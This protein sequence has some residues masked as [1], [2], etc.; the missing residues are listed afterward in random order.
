[1]TEETKALVESVGFVTEYTAY[2]TRILANRKRKLKMYRVWLRGRFIKP[3][4]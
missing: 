1:M 2:D 4:L 3:A